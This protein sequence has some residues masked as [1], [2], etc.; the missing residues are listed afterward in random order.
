VD[1]TFTP[2]INRV[3]EIRE[4]MRK[5]LPHEPEC[6]HLA[7]ELASLTAE[8]QAYAG[9]EQGRAADLAKRLAEAQEKATAALTAAAKAQDEA[10]VAQRVAT[11]H[12]RRAADWTM[13]MAIATFTMAVVSIVSTFVAYGANQRE[14]AKRIAEARPQFTFVPA[15]SDAVPEST[16]LSY[17]I[18]AHNDGP[19]I[20]VSL[21][22]VR[23]YTLSEEKLG[24]LDIYENSVQTGTLGKDVAATLRVTRDNYADPA[25]PSDSV[26]YMHLCCQ[27]VAAITGRE[28][29][30]E[31]VI[32]FRPVEYAAA[33]TTYRKQHPEIFCGSKRMYSG[34]IVNTNSGRRILWGR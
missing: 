17:S 10:A 19:R 33:D 23:R 31:Q 30:Q 2:L 34:V 14:E 29:Y 20:A 8:I 1:P 25:S 7:A 16:L 15:L 5:R 21:L 11:G 27:Y 26:V 4:L 18:D 9:H 32:Y 28:Y 22:T 12:Q 3:G 6:A 13:V 24:V